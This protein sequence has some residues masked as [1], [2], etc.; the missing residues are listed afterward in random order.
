M[1]LSEI[2]VTQQNY[3]FHTA[4]H[5]RSLQMFPVASPRIPPERRR[6][7]G[8]QCRYWSLIPFSGTLCKQTEESSL[9]QLSLNE[10][11]GHSLII[12]L[13]I[14]DRIQPLIV[15]YWL[16]TARAIHLAQWVTH[17][18]VSLSPIT[19]PEVNCLWRGSRMCQVRWDVRPL[20][21]GNEFKFGQLSRCTA[22]CT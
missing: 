16:L 9:S 18:L 6:A 17:S 10:R 8:T 12:S 21:E 13:I 2:R 19:Q 1:T 14:R 11:S 20:H 5:E 15:R 3:C 22:C 4:F 7:P